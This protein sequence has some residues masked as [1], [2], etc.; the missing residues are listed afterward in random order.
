MVD[1]N[2]AEVKGKGIKGIAVTN[3]WAAVGENT[4][5]ITRSGMWTGVSSTDTIGLLS[6]GVTAI[7]TTGSFNDTTEGRGLA[8]PTGAVAN[9][10]AG[11]RWTVNRFRREWGNYMVLRVS[12]SSTSDISVFIGWSNDNA[13]I[14]GANPL[15][16][17]SG[18]GVGK[19]TGDTNWFTI[20]NDGDATEDRVDT[21]LA[22]ATTAV[23]IQL[24]L[25]ATSFRS[26]IGTTTP[27]AVTSELPSSTSMLYPKVEI[28]TGSGAADKTINILPI[29]AR[30]GTVEE[31]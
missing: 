16:T 10:N 12:F 29:W 3:P 14:V 8:F 22:F 21:G 6:G 1:Y 11:L 7:G 18:C 19:R 28:E 2:I 23:T 24:A 5:S 15:N 20:V 30:T 31:I 17:F 26:K 25:D 13:E 4:A 27:A 9:N